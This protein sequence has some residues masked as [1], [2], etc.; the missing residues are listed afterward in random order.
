MRI[1]DQHNDQLVEALARLLV[2]GW[3]SSLPEKTKAAESPAW[4][5][6]AQTDNPRAYEPSCP[7][8]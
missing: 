5:H 6:A 7:Q 8:Q 3:R 4:D 2:A 1:A